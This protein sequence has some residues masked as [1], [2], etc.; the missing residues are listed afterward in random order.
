MNNVIPAFYDYVNQYEGSFAPSEIH[1]RNT[2]LCNFFKKQLLEKAISVFKW[3]LPREWV[4]DYFLYTIYTNGFVCVLNMKDSEKDFGILPQHC[5]LRGYDIQYQPT[6]AI[7][8]NPL[9]N[10]TLE[11]RIDS[12]CVV[13][14]LRPDYTG[15]MDIVNYYA[16]EMAMTCESIDVTTLN[17][18]VSYAF[19]VS[20]KAE[21][22]SMK[23]LY[24]EV[25]SGKPA[26]FFDK[27]L[28][29]GSSGWKVFQNN[30]KQ[31]YIGA[32]LIE[33]LNKYMDM[34]LTEIGLANCNTEKRERMLVDEVN[35]NNEETKSKADM[36]LEHLQEGCRKVNEM[37]N[38]N[39]SVDWRE[40]PK[41]SE[42]ENETNTINS[43]VV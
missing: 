3:N 20:N 39:I 16:S 12:E 36:W 28:T 42:V 25:A 2:G 31:N 29:E 43:R 21:A 1:V 24:D 32:E 27:H 37:F 40:L 41:G 30:L 10:T 13:I 22:E 26:V 38:L 11:P 18:R 9:L 33:V 5:G 19:E 4:K 7:V 8:T 17:S 15:I 14:K 34:Y 6:H 23:K 35:A